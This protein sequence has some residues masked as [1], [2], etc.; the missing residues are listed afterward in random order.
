MPAGTP[1]RRGSPF[2]PAPRRRAAGAVRALALAAACAAVAGCTPFELVTAIGPDAAYTAAED[3]DVGD[4]WDDNVLKMSLNAAFLDDSISLFRDVGTVVYTR[5][6]LLVGT[7][8]DAAARRRAEAIARRH[9]GVRGVVNRIRVAESG[10]LAAYLNDVALE[11]RIQA[12]LL[13]DDAVASANLRVR[14][15]DGTVFLFGGAA[16]PREIERV[17]ATVGGF[18]E[19]R[20]IDNLLWV[21]KGRVDSADGAEPAGGRD[22]DPNRREPAVN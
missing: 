10:G 16:S 18:D 21:R 15:V 1:F 20:R 7:V 2:P 4:V 13:F 9:E 17:V 8:A 19:V 14:A 3:R 11:K 6:V 5:R 22:P 12:D